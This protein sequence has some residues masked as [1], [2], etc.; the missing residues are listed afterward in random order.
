MHV[1]LASIVLCRSGRPNDLLQRF[2]AISRTCRNGHRLPQFLAVG[3]AGPLGLWQTMPQ[4]Q[5][6]A[7]LVTVFRSDEAGSCR[8]DKAQSLIQ[9]FDGLMM[10]SVVG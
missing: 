8:N 7:R 6:L 4:P 9:L 1:A 3:A 10:M 2:F 5:R